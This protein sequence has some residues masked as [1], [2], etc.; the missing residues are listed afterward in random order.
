MAGSQQ[1]THSK[2]HHARPLEPVCVCSFA[3]SRLNKK[4]ERKGERRAKYNLNFQP[5]SGGRSD[6]VAPR[7]MSGIGKYYLD[8]RHLCECDKCDSPAPL[9]HTDPRRSLEYILVISIFISM[10][11]SSVSSMGRFSYADK[12]F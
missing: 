5:R 10:C 7:G 6:C 11:P 2:A 1:Q 3:K 8:A 4:E 9:K 12:C